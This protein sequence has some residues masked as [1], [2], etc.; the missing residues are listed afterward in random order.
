MPVML[1][2]DV[3]DTWLDRDNHD[4]DGLRSFLVPAPAELIRLHPVS[5]DVN[6]VRNNRSSLI[7][8]ATPISDG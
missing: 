2:P 4:V 8:E 1:P 6:N 5:T 3:W 7:E